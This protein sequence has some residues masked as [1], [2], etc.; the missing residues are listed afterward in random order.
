MKYN[1]YIMAVVANFVFAPIAVSQT[2]EPDAALQNA[3]RFQSENAILN[4]SIPFAAQA[5]EA[6][7]NL[8][9]SFGWATFQ[10]GFAREVYFRFDPDGYARFSPSPRLDVDVFEVR[11]QPKTYQCVGNKGALSVHLSADGKVQLQINEMQNGDLLLLDDGTRETLLPD[12]FLL[13]LAPN[14][15]RV[16]FKGGDLKVIRGETQVNMTS[17]TG[18][19]ATVA[20]LKWVASGQ[21]PQA[22][23]GDWPKAGNLGA[24]NMVQVPGVTGWVPPGNDTALI[25]QVASGAQYAALTAQ[26]GIMQLRTDITELKGLLDQQSAGMQPAQLPAAAPILPANTVAPQNPQPSVA[27]QPQV[28]DLQAEITMLSKEIA[29]LRQAAP[30]QSQPMYPEQSAS[31]PREGSPVTIDTVP[32]PSTAVPNEV[33]HL[34]YLVTEMGLSPKTALMLLQLTKPELNAAAPDLQ[35]SRSYHDTLA[36]TILAELEADLSNTITQSITPTP[37]KVE[38]KPM[39]VQPA[40]APVLTLEESAPAEQIDQSEQVA[41]ETTPEE[42]FKPLSDYIQAVMGEPQ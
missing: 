15:E 41:S 34:Q 11:C 4:T 32:M 24:P 5:R 35:V 27:A 16:L 8:R 22:L 29:A 25:G 26:A 6:Q 23:P 2:L 36:R 9:G 38:D 12:I 17:L 13:P 1:R 21:N 18:L 7:Q 20:Y 10:E 40:Q 30:V 39:V 33:Q 37:P 28:S 14:L 31:W 19:A 3:D 42:G